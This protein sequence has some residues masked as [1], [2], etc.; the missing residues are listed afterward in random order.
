MRTTAFVF[1]LALVIGCGKSPSTSQ[2]NSAPQPDQPGGPPNP[3]PKQETPA[4]PSQPSE[5]DALSQPAKDGVRAIDPRVLKAW[6]AEFSKD[7]KAA[8]KKYQGTRWSFEYRPNALGQQDPS[9]P[10]L[11]IGG[12]DDGNESSR[13]RVDVLMTDANDVKKVYAKMGRPLWIEADLEEVSTSNI[14]TAT[15]KNAKIAP[16]K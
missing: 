7:A 15:F 12:I 13:W 1:A 5:F 10:T 14:L 3:A 6:A 8:K 11:V 2:P 16:G 9:N 4:P